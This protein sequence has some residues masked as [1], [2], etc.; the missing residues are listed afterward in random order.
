META[1]GFANQYQLISAM[2]LIGRTDTSYG[3]SMCPP[4]DLVV[5]FH[6]F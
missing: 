3:F 5:D 4:E 6:M 1:A 2:F